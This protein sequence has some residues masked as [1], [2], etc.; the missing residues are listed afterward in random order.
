MQQALLSVEAALTLALAALPT[1]ANAQRPGADVGGGRTAGAPASAGGGGGGAAMTRCTAPGSAPMVRSGPA[2]DRFAAR[3]GGTRFAAPSGGATWSG[4]GTW[5]S[6]HH[7][8]RPGVAFGF[9]APPTPAT[10]T[11]RRRT[12][13]TAAIGFG[14]C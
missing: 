3:S 8:R 2:G 14:A 6:R 11:T 1:C 5:R 12:M 10:V 4:G 7:F 9:A 13:T